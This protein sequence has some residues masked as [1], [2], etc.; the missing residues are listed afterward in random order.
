[1][2]NND[3]YHDEVTLMKWLSAIIFLAIVG[4]HIIGLYY[5]YKE[6]KPTVKQVGWNAEYTTIE[7]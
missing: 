7:R 2:L 6:D 1:M 3:N 4:A 5:D